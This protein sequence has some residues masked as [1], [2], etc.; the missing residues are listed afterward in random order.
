MILIVCQPVDAGRQYTNVELRTYFDTIFF[1]RSHHSFIFLSPL[2]KATLALKYGFLMGWHVDFIY[3]KE[4]RT[5]FIY[6]YDRYPHIA[7]L[8]EKRGIGDNKKCV[9]N[10]RE[11]ELLGDRSTYTFLPRYI[12]V[13]SSAWST[14]VTVRIQCTAWLEIA[15]GFWTSS[16]SYIELQDNSMYLMSMLARPSLHWLFVT[17][18]FHI[19]ETWTDQI[20]EL[21]LSH[22]Y[23]CALNSSQ[24]AERLSDWLTCIYKR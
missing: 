17:L 16:E 7:Y 11:I 22:L 18:L 8:D 13:T 12:W 6:M 2:E 3:D 5:N 23:R 14:G 24:S 10:S 1:S 20:V 19:K 9:P 21:K 4:S 15:V